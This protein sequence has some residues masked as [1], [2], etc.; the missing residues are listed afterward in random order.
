MN[1]THVC[2]AVD[3]VKLILFLYVCLYETSPLSYSFLS[4]SPPSSLSFFVQ[5]D[6]AW[7][8]INSLGK[9]KLNSIS[10]LYGCN[11]V[12]ERNVCNFLPVLYLSW[13]QINGLMDGQS[14]SFSQSLFSHH[15]LHLH[16]S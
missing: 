11:C 3:G 12:F 6:Q 8:Y 2:T 9:R 7:S 4:V 15:Y 10:Q 16:N 1:K 13:G 5:T 14:Y